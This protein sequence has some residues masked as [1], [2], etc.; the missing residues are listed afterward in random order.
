MK[1]KEIILYLDDQKYGQKMQ[2]YMNQKKLL[3][4]PICGFT[5]ISK[6]KEYCAEHEIA[7][8][9]T[10]EEGRKKLLDKEIREE[11]RNQDGIEHAKKP[12]ENKENMKFVILTDE[13]NQEGIYKYQNANEI[14]KLIL[15]DSGYESPS[16]DEKRTQKGKL[17]GIYSPIGRCL[18]TSFSLVLGQ[19]LAKK[20]RVLYLNFESFSGF[21]QLLCRERKADVTDLLYYLKNIKTEFREQVGEIRLS[22]NGLDYIP[23]ALSFIDLM[24]VTCEQWD[25]LLDELFESGMYDYILLDLSDHIQ[26][27]FQ[28][29]NR[30]SHV[31]MMVKNDG[32]ALAKVSQYEE[33]LKTLQYEDVIRRTKKCNLPLFH[34][35]PVNISELVYSELGDAVRQITKDDFN[36]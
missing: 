33:L 32:M 18:K 26:G 24:S 6:V 21:A 34:N 11:Q 29:L 27:L 20:Y 4:F 2:N 19:M 25:E 28:I 31:Y 30:C 10:D 8:C 14:A 35:L 22:M 15:L 5:E 9:L 23:P 1:G 7:F 12:D 16:A 17:I 3:P 36:W 13:R